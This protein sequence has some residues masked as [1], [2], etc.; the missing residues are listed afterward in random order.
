MPAGNGTWSAISTVGTNLGEV[1][2]PTCG[3]VDIME[4]LGFDPARI[5]LAAHMAAYNHVTQNAK[6]ASVVV[7]KPWETF[8]VYAIEWY[9]DRIDWYVD[10]QLCF[11]FENVRTGV[12]AWPFDGKQY[13]LM[14]L[15][16]GGSWG[17]RMGVDDALFPHR[18]LVDYVRA[19]EQG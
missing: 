10:E 6:R 5:H 7:E 8:H 19:Y 9:P 12:L 4:H 14:N 1:S 3:E 11:T 15:V 2:W 13:L 18:L 17:S 16:I